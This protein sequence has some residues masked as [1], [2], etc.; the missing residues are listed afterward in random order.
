[1]I[2]LEAEMKMQTH[3]RVLRLITVVLLSYCCIPAKQTLLPPGGGGLLLH[4]EGLWLPL[5]EEGTDICQ[6]ERRAAHLFLKGT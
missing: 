4:P 1:M 6:G 3:F 2:E 5:R